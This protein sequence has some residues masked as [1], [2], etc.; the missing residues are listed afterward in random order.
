MLKFLTTW[1]I[2]SLIG[3]TAI[4]VLG[5]A[6]SKAA[7]VQEEICDET[8]DYAL[9]LEDYAAAITF[10]RKF[11]HSHP[12]DALAHYHLGFAYGMTGQSS[13]EIRE[14]LKAVRLGLR[15]WDLFLDLGLAYFEE[16]DYP[17][18]I[19]ALETSVSLGRRHPE[20]HF[21]LAMA[22]EKADRLN[23]AMKEI[24]ASLQLAPTDLGMRNAKAIICAESGD[25]NCAYDQWELL[26]KTAPNYTPAQ[27]NLEI[28]MGSDPPVRHS[29]ASTAEIR[30][31]VAVRTWSTNGP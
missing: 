6:E 28:L 10:H 14:Y 20:T 25:L 18:A 8:A 26:V 19:D 22:Y 29:S 3:V 24:D 2:A 15:V 5:I 9:R 21:N 4:F 1:A 11:L 31:S 23:D 7:L 30:Q 13:R 27:T 17:K 16:S 12:A